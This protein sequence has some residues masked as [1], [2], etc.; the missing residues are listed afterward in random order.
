MELREFIQTTLSQIAEAVDWANNGN[1]A[2]GAIVGRTGTIVC[3]DIEFDVAISATESKETNGG[4][5][6]Q[7][8][9]IFK[10]G[11]EKN[12]T[13]DKQ[14]YSHIRFKIPLQYWIK[15]I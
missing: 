7:V 15:S 5:G 14:E 8:A 10:T 1:L 2:G 3:D 6:L 11:V 4:A 9:S 12:K 13:Q